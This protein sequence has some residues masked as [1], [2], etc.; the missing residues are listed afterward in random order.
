V[1]GADLVV[2]PYGS[3][4]VGE[5]ACWAGE[6][7][8]VLWNHGAARRRRTAPPGVVSV[9]PPASSYLAAALRWQEA[10]GGA[11]VVA[12]GGGTFGRQSRPAW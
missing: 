12:A 1:A 2:S 10:L 3:D 5:A 4:L 7:G 6:R 9:A 11:R 8:R